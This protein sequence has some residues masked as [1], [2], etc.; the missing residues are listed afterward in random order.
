MSATSISPP[1]AALGFWTATAIVV[2]SMIGT[3]V[4]TSLGFQVAGTPSVFPLLLLWAVGGVVA[5][6]GALSYGE[7]AAALP[8]S[9][10][11]YHYLS[12][13]YHPAVGFLSGWASATVGFA[14][15][16]ALAAVAL[17]EYVHR[18]YPA[19]SVRGLA[20]G[21]VLA[22]A[23][24]HSRSVRVG[25]QI[26]LVLT[27]LKVAVVLL[28]IG[29][30]CWP[31][32]PD[33]LPPTGALPAA[34]DGALIISPAFA[35]SLVY[36]SYAYSGWNAAAYVA[37]EIHEPQRNLPRILLTGTALVAV[38]YISLN[39]A[40]LRVT[41]LPALTGELEVGLL[42]ARRL[43]SP[44]IA[45]LMGLTIAALLTSSISAMTFAGPRIVQTI[46]EDVPAL[47]WLGHRQTTSGVP[48]RALLLQTGLTLAFVL[49]GSFQRVLVY[50]GFV[51]SLFTFLTV[52]GVFV[53]RFR[54]PDLPRPYRAWGYP[55]TPLVFLALT[56][57]TL[58]FLIQ[59]QPTESLAGLATLLIG[60]PLYAA[61]TH[62]RSAKR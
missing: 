6:C 23:F 35:V 49:T 41:P 24:V 4:F 52:A 46:G 14:A 40:F 45:N 12:V 27:L 58:W 7:L 21:V 17:G 10:G 53:L 8:R 22:L 26:Q 50:A 47:R 59:Q 15:P 51:L 33:V 11:E 16:T 20:A 42:A 62:P 28:I 61:L 48:L 13:I 5:L 2:A 44:T 19:T 25:G 29:A 34:G 3:G 1:R 38:L 30:A 54:H 55:V 43:F 57:W 37:G 9:G 60:L 39:Y 31:G 36:V 18:I 32:M 56:G